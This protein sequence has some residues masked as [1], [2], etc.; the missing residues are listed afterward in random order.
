MR[1][2]LRLTGNLSQIK[3]GRH[4]MTIQQ[5]V[6][7][8]DSLGELLQIEYDDGKINIEEQCYGNSA[9]KALKERILSKTEYMG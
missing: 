8:I 3:E 7:E 1:S 6:D 4:D 5:V 9:L 2:G